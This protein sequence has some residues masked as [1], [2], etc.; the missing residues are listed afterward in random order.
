MSPIVHTLV[1]FAIFV[2]VVCGGGMIY[3]YHLK[4]H[5]KIEEELRQANIQCAKILARRQIEVK[6]AKGTVIDLVDRIHLLKD[7]IRLV[8]HN[9]PGELATFHLRNDIYVWCRKN[10]RG[11]CRMLPFVYQDPMTMKVWF[12]NP[13]DALWFKMKWL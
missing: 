9:R 6:Y 10:L 7:D 3:A 1:V 4:Q 8:D 13:D 12:E 2:I 11:R 5:Y